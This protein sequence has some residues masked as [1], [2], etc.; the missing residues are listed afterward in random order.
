MKMLLMVIGLLSIGGT[1]L[2]LALDLQGR[3]GGAAWLRRTRSL[4]SQPRSRWA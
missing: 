2:A 3:R 4:L 1:P